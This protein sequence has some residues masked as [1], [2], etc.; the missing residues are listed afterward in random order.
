MSH[1][2]RPHAFSVRVAP[3]P[4]GKSSGEKERLASLTGGMG[5]TPNEDGAMLGVARWRGWIMPRTEWGLPPSLLAASVLAVE[6]PR[7]CRSYW[8]RAT[9][10]AARPAAERGHAPL[11][12]VRKVLTRHRPRGG[13]EATSSREAAL[14]CSR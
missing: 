12:R 14:P 10:R 4:P 6:G 3:C 2:E 9:P 13:Q 5:T 1:P 8:G 11:E 7:G